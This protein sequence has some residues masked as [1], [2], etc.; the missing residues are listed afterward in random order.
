MEF[1]ERTVKEWLEDVAN[2]TTSGELDDVR[3]QNL[4]HR[5][6]FPKAVSV[7]GIVYIEGDGT[8]RH[9]PLPI[10]SMARTILN[11]AKEVIK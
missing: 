2:S 5:V 4:L 9:P 6:G 1:K 10:Q 11:S 3:M 8:L 7:C